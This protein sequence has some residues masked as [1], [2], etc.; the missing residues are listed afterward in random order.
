MEV[1]NIYYLHVPLKMSCRYHL[2]GYNG[3]TRSVLFFVLLVSLLITTALAAP[4]KQGFVVGLLRPD[5]LII[6]FAYFNGTDFI[7][8]WQKPRD[9]GP[10]DPNTITDL[11][12]PW[13]SGLTAPTQS[14]MSKLLRGSVS[15][16]AKSQE[17]YTDKSGEK[18]G[19]T[20]NHDNQSIA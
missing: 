10:T 18:G 6:P 14:Q 4:S 11:D 9:Y 1:K 2:I 17:E 12:V 7:N 13:F 20:D 8:P 5:G 3:F 19:K 16:F 15:L